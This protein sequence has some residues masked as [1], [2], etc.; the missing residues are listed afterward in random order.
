MK[1]DPQSV[2]YA[3]Q[4]SVL[5]LFKPIERIARVNTSVKDSELKDDAQRTVLMFIAAIIAADNSY[6]TGQKSFLSVLVNTDNF[7][8]GEPRYLKEY[9]ARWEEA[10]KRTPKFIEVARE[11]DAQNKSDMV[12]SMLLQIQ[13]I[14][15]TAATSDGAAS[16]ARNRVVLQYIEFL[17]KK[18]EPS[19]KVEMPSAT[20]NVA[21]TPVQQAPAPVQA[22]PPV[23]QAPAPVQIP[24]PVP[25]PAPAPVQQAPA[26]IQAP[27]PVQQAPAPVQAPQPVQQAPAP[28]KIP[29]PAPV[30]TPAPVQ[31]APAP[32]QA[33]APAPASAPAPATVR[34]PG[35]ASA[36]TPAPAPAPV[37]SAQSVPPPVPVRTGDSASRNWT[38]YK[39]A[40]SANELKAYL[41][42]PKD[43]RARTPHPLAKDWEAFLA[44]GRPAKNCTILDAGSVANLFDIPQREKLT[45]GQSFEVAQTIESLG[46]IVEPDSRH[47]SAYTWDQELAVF[48]PVGAKITSPSHNYLGASVLLKLCVLVASADGHATPEELAVS[49]R[50]V[51]PNLLLGPD[52]QR[53][54][55]AL[56]Q[57]LADK[58]DRINVPLARVARAIPKPLRDLICEGLVCVAAADRPVNQNEI[59]VLE[60]IYKAFELPPE[61]LEAQ[62][63]SVGPNPGEAAAHVDQLAQLTSEVVGLLSEVVTDAEVEF[64]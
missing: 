29:A 24:T 21:P 32:V 48:K 47:E 2:A 10:S 17:E 63:K 31:Q 45:P 1:N 23:Q 12:R 26:P 22:P 35:Q 7:P 6:N 37:Q 49:L 64:R 33:P 14:G 8:G 25:A 27:P 9:A 38:T 20:A 16:S 28:V 53:R 36:P 46:Y 52:D 13:M 56:E 54:L 3:V 58:P 41:A 19:I 4:S 62:I 15:N 43:Q 39:P 57:I 5:E 51:G 60:R 59:T 42:L 61:K 11:H 30:P 55:E 40:I 34:I 44:S 50:F 18:P